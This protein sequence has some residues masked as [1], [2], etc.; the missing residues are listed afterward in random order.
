MAFYL[1]KL[2]N[3]KYCSAHLLLFFT[4]DLDNSSELFY[5]ETSSAK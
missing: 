3:S 4:A 5:P 2:Y 1:T